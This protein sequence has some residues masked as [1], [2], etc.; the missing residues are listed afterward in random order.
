M[1][2]HSCRWYFLLS[3]LFFL[4]GLLALLLRYMSGH[5]SELVSPE[6]K[7]PTMAAKPLESYAFSRLRELNPQKS[8]IVID[9]LLDG[10]N[11]QASFVFSFMSN[12]KKM[13]GHLRVPQAATPSAG[14]PVVL[15]LRGFVDQSIYET[16]IGTRNASSFF[17]QHGYVTIAPDF[18]GYG[19]SDAPDTDTMAARVMRPRHVIDLIASLSSLNFVN[20]QDVYMW[21]HSNGGQIALS[22]LEIT[23]KSI[24]T[25]L[26]A[27]VSKPFPYSIL[28]YT[29]EYEDGGKALRKV[30]ASFESMYDV[31]DFSIHKYLEW[32][33]SP[34]QI[35]QGTADDAV[36]VEWSNDLV[37]SLELLAKEIAYFVY[38][39]A[40]HNLQ[41]N[42]N[43]AMTRDLEFFR[44][45][46]P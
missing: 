11:D 45:F 4:V 26:W 10:D 15:L 14:F 22:V 31:D 5:E 44:E 16:G 9:E 27:P 3:L 32:I 20:A 43:T 38:P 36:P 8:Q 17:A 33:Q 46:S 34:I 7:F 6:S 23:G 35:H 24:P 29:D 1:R 42:W 40:D 13:T 25:T 19:G 37:S 39:G 30:L 21:A 18:L 2:D 41:P 28:Y 12:G